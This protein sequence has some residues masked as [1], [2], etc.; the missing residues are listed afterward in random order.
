MTSGSSASGLYSLDECRLWWKRVGFDPTPEQ[1]AILGD[2]HRVKL[3][4]G[5]ERAGKSR[6]AGAYAL[7]RTLDADLIWLIAADYRLSL[8]EFGYIHDDL[9]NL[10]MLAKASIPQNEYQPR[11]LMTKWGCEVRT[12]TA[13]DESKIGMLAPDG[14]ILAEAANLSYSI[15]LRVRARVAEKRGWVFMEGT[16]EK[17]EDWYVELWEDWKGG[18][19]EDEISF[20]LPTWSNRAIFPGGFDD[21]EIQAL[22]RLLSDTRFY[23]RHGGIPSPPS[24]AV[25][26]EFRHE[27][28]VGLY[29][30]DPN[31]PVELAIDPGY[32]GA[33]AVV[34]LQWDNARTYA[35]DAIYEQGKGT[36]EIIKIAR[37][38]PW[39]PAVNPKRGGVI[40]IAGK[41]HQ[42]MRSHV[43]M[44]AEHP[45]NGGAGIY[46]QSIYVPIEDG[47]ERYRSFLNDPVTGNPRLFY[48]A[49]TT[50]PAVKEHK[51]YRYPEDKAGRAQRERPIDRDNHAIKAVTYWL[52][53]RYGFVKSKP[54]SVKRATF[55]RPSDATNQLPFGPYPGS[56][57]IRHASDRFRK[58]R[59]RVGRFK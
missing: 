56:L 30:Y 2:S 42:G 4:A 35:I 8:A 15:Y 43:E 39:W 19:D 55:G 18:T 11:S 3:V 44:W 22:K 17:A 50:G 53:S 23:E 57:G 13:A 1:A 51:L 28:H 27:H 12:L 10:G 26:P 16:F 25:F 36:P 58:Q 6:V 52:V 49:D 24:T 40:D 34:A 29:P 46:L 45:S 9:V 21:P 38:R 47:I 48:N 54:K 59:V 32:A 33:Y 14:V 5:G 41:Q 20:S 37:E 7:P 31:R